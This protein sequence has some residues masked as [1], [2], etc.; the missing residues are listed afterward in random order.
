MK[1]NDACKCSTSWK[2]SFTCCADKK[3]EQCRQIGIGIAEQIFV[4][5]EKLDCIIGPR[6]PY[7]VFAISWH[8]GSTEKCIPSFLI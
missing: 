1:S 4:V 2:K 7:P 8:R 6:N 3:G 5:E